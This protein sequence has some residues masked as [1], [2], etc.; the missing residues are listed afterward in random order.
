[1]TT[2]AQQTFLMWARA[3]PAPKRPKLKPSAL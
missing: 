2:A 1:M 3:W